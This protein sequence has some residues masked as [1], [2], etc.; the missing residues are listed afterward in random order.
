M[1]IEFIS[2]LSPGG[3]PTL[4]RISKSKFKFRGKGHEASELLP[5]LLYYFLTVNS[6]QTSL[7]YCAHINSGWM[8]SI[9]AL[10]LQMAFESSSSWVTPNRC[11]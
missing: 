8:T 3:I 7:Y 6:S 4:R 5:S 1:L 11:R 2:L 9:R 10:N